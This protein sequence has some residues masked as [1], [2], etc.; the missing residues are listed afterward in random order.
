MSAL[1][2]SQG[3]NVELTGKSSI[4]NLWQAQQGKKNCNVKLIPEYV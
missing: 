1:M 2:A 3:N 4:G